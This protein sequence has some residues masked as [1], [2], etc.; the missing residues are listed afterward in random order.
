MNQFKNA[1]GV[2][3]TRD[4]FYETAGNR[5]NAIFT[6]KNE[7]TEF[8]GKLYKSLYLLYMETNDVTEY[9]FAVTHLDSWEHWKALST[10]T[11][12][13]P[14]VSRW[15][16]ELEVRNRSL[17][18]AKI[19]QAASGGTRDAFV[20]A[21]YIAEGWDKPKSGRGRPSKEAIKEAA[22]DI[23]ED[24]RKVDQDYLRLIKS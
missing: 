21:K 24:K 20:A 16:E 2:Y 13:Q 10:S 8:E 14:Y 5:E 18:L 17:A 12:F 7:D 3:L 4:L 6:L 11:F 9:A 1:N 15:R 23:A 22:Y 19:M